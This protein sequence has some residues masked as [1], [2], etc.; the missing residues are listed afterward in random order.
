MRY[1][2]TISI[3]NVFV[4]PIDY[5]NAAQIVDVALGNN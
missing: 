2:I 5:I 3:H 4:K 1:V